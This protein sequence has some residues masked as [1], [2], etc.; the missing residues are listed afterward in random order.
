M[1]KKKKDRNIATEEEEKNFVKLK[2]RQ[3][4]ICLRKERKQQQVDTQRE[5]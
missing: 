4:D 1:K 2:H 5:K 3:I